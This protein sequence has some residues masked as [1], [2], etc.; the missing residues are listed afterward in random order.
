[1]SSGCICTTS[2]AAVAGL[3]G[4]ADSLI[5]RFLSVVDS[6]TQ[7]WSRLC[8]PAATDR[9]TATSIITHG[10]PGYFWI[11]CASCKDRSCESSRPAKRSTCM[12]T[13]LYALRVQGKTKVFADHMPAFAYFGF[14]ARNSGNFRQL[15]VAA[16]RAGLDTLQ[17][18]HRSVRPRPCP[19][20]KAYLLVPVVRT[21]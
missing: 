16:R 20:F 7:L 17:F 19:C 11:W 14:P 4:R 21:G 5:H 13:R 18:T 3:P 10:A 12:L 8:T 9:E 1:M 6:K 2:C 15:V